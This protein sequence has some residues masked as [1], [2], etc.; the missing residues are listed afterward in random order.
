MLCQL[1][2]LLPPG[3]GERCVPC[4]LF[5][6]VVFDVVPEGPAAAAASVAVPAATAASCGSFPRYVGGGY[7]RVAG[8]RGWSGGIG[9]GLVWRRG[10]PSCGFSSGRGG[11]SCGGNGSD[12]GLGVTWARTPLARPFDPGKG[13]SRDPEGGDC[14]E[15]WLICAI[16]DRG[17]WSLQ[18]EE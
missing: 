15:G 18:L 8:I 2:L 6:A 10:Y 16:R 14:R 17:F 7:G 12:E 5:A 1:H 3:L 9:G 4:G 13:S 11:R